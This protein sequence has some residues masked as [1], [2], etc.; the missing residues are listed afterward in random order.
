MESGTNQGLAFYAVAFNKLARQH[1]C[2]KSIDKKVSHKSPA[3][4]LF[5]SPVISKVDDIKF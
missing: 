2:R 3:P 4:G 1:S 5:H